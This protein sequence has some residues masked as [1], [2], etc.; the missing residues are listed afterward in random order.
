[1]KIYHYTKFNNF[2]SIWIQQKLLFSEWTN[3]NDIY[4]RE[5]I[6]NLTQDSNKFH[7]KVFSFQTFRKLIDEVFKEVAR[8][9]QVSFCLDFEDLKG[10]ESPM[11][12]GQYARDYQRS[13]VCIELEST[14]LK[15]IPNGSDIYEG[16]VCYKEMLSPT[17]IINVDIEESDAIQNYVIKN[18]DS[19]FFQKHYHWSHENEYRIISKNADYIDISHAITHVYVLNTDEITVECVKR[20]T[21]N[22]KK[23]ELISVGGIN[24]VHMSSTNLY[25]LEH[26]RAELQKLNRLKESN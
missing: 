24:N 2:C 1:M 11:M 21:K 6:Y 4:E 7:D 14:K 12:W 8:Y 20:I 18:K 13:G 16:K 3:S 15:V 17:D 5:K 19:L 26:D 22:S 9:K 23:V 10:Y 25:T